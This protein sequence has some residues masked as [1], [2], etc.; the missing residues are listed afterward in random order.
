M[1][2]TSSHQQSPALPSYG[3]RIIYN[4]E[5]YTESGRIDAPDDRMKGYHKA[6]RAR[7]VD[8]FERAGRRDAPAG[9]P[10][11]ERFG[12]GRPGS[13][14]PGQYDRSEG[15]GRQAP[16]LHSAVC[17]KCGNACEVP[18]KPRPGRPVLCRECFIKQDSPRDRSPASD[19]RGADSS[20]EL[21]QDMNQKLDKIMRALRI[22]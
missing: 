20:K 1:T 2:A 4:Q 8:R 12:S 19:G 16:S 3:Y 22:H 9:R 21:L 17:A 11:R 13:R 7:P 10:P 14:G 18:F 5:G 15:E 6:E